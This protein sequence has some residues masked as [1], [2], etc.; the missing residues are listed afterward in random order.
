MSDQP[1]TVRLKAIRVEAGVGTREMA[2]RLG[3]S[4]STYTHYENPARFKGQYLPM[5][6]AIRFADAL[7]PEGVDRALVIG[8]AGASHSADGDTID[9]RV[10]K[11]S[12]RRHEM[13]LDLLQD[14]EAAEEVDLKRRGKPDDASS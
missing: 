5:E 3:I 13:I 9:D 2:R 10:A 4:T 7:E 12:K 14:L 6:W 11:L 1:V 8:L